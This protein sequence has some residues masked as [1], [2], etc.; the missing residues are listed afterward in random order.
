MSSA[1]S[2][3]PARHASGRSAT[4]EEAIDAAPSMPAP[5][6]G[7]SPLERHKALE[8]LWSSGRGLQRLSSVNHTVLGIRIMLTAS[9]FF[10]VGGLL[11]MLIRAQLATPETASWTRLPMRRSSPCTGR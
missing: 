5:V 7:L 8:A 10:G 3:P 6:D 1:S 4:V 2:E 9:V 11:A